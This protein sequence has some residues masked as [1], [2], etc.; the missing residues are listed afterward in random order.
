MKAFTI[1]LIAV[2]LA[3]CSKKEEEANPTL[4]TNDQFE[5]SAAADWKLVNGQ[6]IDTYVG[7]YQK[8]NYRIAFD[9]GNLA[10]D[11]IDSIKNTPELIHYEELRIDGNKAKIIKENRSDG[12]RL[13]AFIDKGD[14]LAK[15][16][17]YTFNTSN[18]QLF[19][20]VVKS[21]QF[22]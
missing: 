17:L 15:N 11:N 12:A 14:G 21:H 4:H 2:A 20:D 16:R 6:G 1:L 10:F 13:T 18:D 5:L 9:Y 19:I 3:S 8:A 22:K 7:Y